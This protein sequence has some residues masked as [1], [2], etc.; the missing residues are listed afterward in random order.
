P[1]RTGPLGFPRD[2]CRDPR[3]LRGGKSGG[4]SGRT[5]RRSRQG[6]VRDTVSRGARCD[7][8]TMNDA[9]REAIRA[10]ASY[11]REV[12]PVDPE[13]IFEYVEGQPHPAVVREELREM[14]IDLGLR[15]RDDG[16]FVPVSD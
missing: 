10:N 14:A 7:G 12:R 15:E 1:R 5:Y 11:L 2:L 6:R 4:H 3:Y 8:W 16:T 13:E 9:Q